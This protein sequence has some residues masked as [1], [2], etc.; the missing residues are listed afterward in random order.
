MFIQ[1]KFKKAFV[2]DIN[3]LAIFFS[4]SF[5]VFFFSYF[6]LKFF[7]LLIFIF[8]EAKTENSVEKMGGAWEAWL[9]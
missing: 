6:F 3:K 5:L 2:N 8:C 7:L 9:T 4:F 1:I